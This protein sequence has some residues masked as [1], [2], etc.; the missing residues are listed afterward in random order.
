MDTASKAEELKIKAS[1]LTKH[2]FLHRRE[3]TGSSQG[4]EAYKSGDYTGAVSLY[5]SAIEVDPSNYH[6]LLNRS[7]AYLKLRRCGLRSEHISRKLL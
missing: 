3:L 1:I 6:C 2:F 7:Q 5:T 4:N